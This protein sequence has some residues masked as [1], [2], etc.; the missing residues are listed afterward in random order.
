M[1]IFITTLVTLGSWRGSLLVMM[2]V[3]LTCTDVAGFMHWWGLT[4]DM[5]SM[6]VLIISVGLCV[7]FCAHIVHGFLTGHGSK[8]ERVLYVMENIAP[9]VLNGG[10]STLLALSLLVT[11]KSHV[12][13]SFFK[14]FFMICVFGLFHGLILLPTVLCMVGPSDEQMVK[15]KKKKVENGQTQTPILKPPKKVKESEKYR[16]ENEKNLQRENGELGLPLNPQS[17]ES[18]MTSDN[19]RE[20]AL[21]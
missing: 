20:T 9:A 12:A 6:N 2:C 13:M 5:S 15:Q 14:I 10:F 8:D 1:C 16:K 7:D 4:I 18:F 19:V 3:L 21:V 11:S 17:V